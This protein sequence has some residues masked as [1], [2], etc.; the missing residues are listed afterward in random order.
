MTASQQLN[1]DSSIPLYVQVREILLRQISIGDLR[2]NE[3]LPSERELAEQYGV[4]RM[5]IRQA[6]QTLVR[7]NL[8]YTRVGKGTYVAKPRLEKG[9]QLFGFTEEM[10]RLNRAVSNRVLEFK[11]IPASEKLAEI[12][13]IAS[14]VGVFM[15]K[16]IRIADGVPIAREAAHIPEYIYPDLMRHNFQNESLYQVLRE[17]C[18]MHLVSAEETVEA[19]IATQDEYATL[20]LVPPA[21]IFRFSRRTRSDQNTIV[22]YV[23][24]VNRGDLYIVR[25][26]LVSSPTDPA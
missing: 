13:N 14:G 23:E 12:F 1:V 8:L 19:A 6:V 22:E 10:H 20:E 26:R 17:E 11:R 16:R 9:P 4:S 24:A 7:S 18:G 15:L 2:E 21:A 5:T 25:T 3:R